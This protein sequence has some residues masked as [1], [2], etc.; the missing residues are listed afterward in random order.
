MNILE[1][2]ERNT[3]YAGDDECWTTTFT[4]SP[5]NPYPRLTLDRKTVRVSRVVYEAHHAEPIP[6]GLC[7]CHTCDNPACINPNH[8]FL[9]TH[10]DNMFDKDAKGRA[11][12]IPTFALTQDDYDAIY[13]DE[14]PTAELA[15]AYGVSKGH[16]RR[17]KRTGS[18]KQPRAV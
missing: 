8:L 15:K 6:D 2:I 17:I 9:G 18:G 4:T 7:V 12:H 1:K 14:R 11:N 10:G 13:Q 3:N 16:I 5:T